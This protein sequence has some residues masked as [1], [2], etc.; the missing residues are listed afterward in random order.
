MNN[1]AVGA[2]VLV[3]LAALGVVVWMQQQNANRRARPTTAGGLFGE[4]IGDVVSGAFG[5][6]GLGS[7]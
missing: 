5:I 3:M 2:L 1:A 4:G 6:A 7:S